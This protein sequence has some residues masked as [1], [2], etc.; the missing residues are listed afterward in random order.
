MHL[1]VTGAN[2]FL[3]QYTVANAL[4]QGHQVRAVSRRSLPF[5]GQQA[6]LTWVQ[7]DLSKSPDQLLPLLDNI[8]AVVHL[9]AAV[10]GDFATQ[11]ASTVKATEHLLQAMSRSG[12]TKLI[13]ISSFS[14]YD[15]HLIPENNIL[16]EA[17]PL[18]SVPEQRNIY[19]QMKLKQ[20]QL[21]REFA[22]H[23]GRVT[24]L[25][26]GMIYGPDHLCNAFF[27][28]PIIER[29]WLR[30]GRHAQLPL[31]YVN[32]CADAIIQ[33]IDCPTVTGQTLNIV[34]DDLPNQV[35]YTTLVRE[36]LEKSVISLVI[37]WP[38]MKHLANFVWSLNQSLG[39]RIRLPGLL[40]PAQLQARYKPLRYSNNKAKQMLGWQPQNSLIEALDLSIDVPHELECSEVVTL[41]KR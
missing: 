29:L 14:V 32:H 26:P 6:H 7:A 11:Y 28:T 19:T 3:G 24:I 15:Y 36:R 31:T 2:G 23:G 16:D 22:A 40:T 39:G 1:L 13:A 37:P 21:V 4:Q 20:E 35:T 27:G 25:R 9:A 34:D 10:T 30:V 38:W 8:D 5:G 17:S 12:V 33:A 41:F 18:E